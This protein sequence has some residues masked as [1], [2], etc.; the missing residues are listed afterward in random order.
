MLSFPLSNLKPLDPLSQLPNKAVRPNLTRPP[1]SFPQNQC[2]RSATLEPR[3]RCLRQSPHSPR[4][5]HLLREANPLY[6]PRSECWRYLHCLAYPLPC[7]PAQHPATVVAYH[8][9]TPPLG[10]SPWVYG[11]ATRLRRDGEKWASVPGLRELKE[12]SIGIF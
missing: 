7:A 6:P 11:Q 4:D 9:T 8:L 10:P 12:H 2:T 3:P 5:T 1:P